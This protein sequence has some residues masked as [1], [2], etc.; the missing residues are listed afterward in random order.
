[1][2]QPYNF[3]SG[4]GEMQTCKRVLFYGDSNTFGTNPEAGPNGRYP[5]K[6]RWPCLLSSSLHGKWAVLTDALPGRCIPSLQFE[7]ENLYHCLQKHPFL[8][9]FAVMLGTNDY[10]SI[11]HPDANAVGE[12]FRCFIQ[13]LRRGDSPLSLTVPVLVIAPPYLDFHENCW[14]RPY[15]TTDGSLSSALQ[16]A[17]IDCGMEENQLLFLDSGAWKLPLCNDGIHLSAQGHHLFSHA[18][19]AFLQKAVLKE[20]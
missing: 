16:N 17:V 8:D 10:L 7:W 15:D 12:R 3:I 11:G 1:M 9:L 2:Q 13:Q 18:V 19:S 5:E 20:S 6:D 14:Y 4:E